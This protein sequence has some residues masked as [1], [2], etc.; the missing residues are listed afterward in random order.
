MQDCNRCPICNA[1]QFEQV[2][3][4]G[5]AHALLRCAACG[6]LFV[7]PQPSH[8]GLTESYSVGS[9][10]S[11]DLQGQMIL[12]P[13]KLLIARDDLNQIRRLLPSGRLFEVGCGAGYFLWY[14][15]QR[16]Y[17]VA[18]NEVSRAL[19]QFAREQ[20]QVD[21]L[22]GDLL[23][24][25][26]EG[27]W[28]VVYMRNVLSHL[29][30]PVATLRKVHQLLRPGGLVFIETGNVAELSTSRIRALHQM[31]RL[32]VPDHLFFFTRAG[33]R[34]LMQRIGFKPISETCYGVWLHD[35][36]MAKLEKRARSALQTRSLN[37]PKS[38]SRKSSL[39]GYASYLLAY[40]IGRLLPCRGRKCSIKYLFQKV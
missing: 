31:G 38:V 26:I 10:V 7:Y 36:L 30:D 19:V 2:M 35:W 27:N 40:P 13:K 25:E 37:S 21:V 9:A 33:L 20:L 16:G 14:A 6:V 39:I 4:V 15:K 17:E 22:E 23:Q 8:E 18:G 12:T 1:E 11:V 34:Q 29:P 5:N 28:D 24:L 32:G 3:S